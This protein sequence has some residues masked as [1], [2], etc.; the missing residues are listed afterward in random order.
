MDPVLSVPTDFGGLLGLQNYEPP[1][2]PKT[3]SCWTPAV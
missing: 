3:D 2:V 1:R